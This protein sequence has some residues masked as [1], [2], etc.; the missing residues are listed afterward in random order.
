MR[1]RV[2]FPWSGIQMNQVWQRNRGLL[3]GS[4]G[5]WL[6]RAHEN[7]V[8]RDA[9]MGNLLHLPFLHVAACAIIRRL[10]VFANTQRQPTTLLDMAGQAFLSEIL[11]RLLA[12]RLYVRVVAADA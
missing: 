3:K 5:K 1:R 4:V 10:L 9:G 11:R 7:A 6:I 8:I 2:F 12:R